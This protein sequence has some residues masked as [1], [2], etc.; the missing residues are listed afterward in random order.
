MN[1]F[2]KEILN[3]FREDRDFIDLGKFEL[4]RLEQLKEPVAALEDNIKKMLGEYKLSDTGKIM[5]IFG[6]ENVNNDAL[7]LENL[8]E[9][10]AKGID[11]VTEAKEAYKQLKEYW[12][13]SYDATED[14]LNKQIEMMDAAIENY[15]HNIRLIELTMGEDSYSN[16]REYQESIAETSK[17]IYEIKHETFLYWQQELSQ[18]KVGTEE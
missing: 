17:D 12:I 14:L 11:V 9:M 10:Q 1:D 7:L 18:L 4:K 6:A 15:Q 8:K 2:E 13:S 3:D 5:S 16:I